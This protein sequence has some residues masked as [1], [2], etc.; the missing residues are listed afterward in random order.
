[1]AENH[2]YEWEY[3]ELKAEL[4]TRFVIEEHFG[5]FASVKD[6]KDLM[7]PEEVNLL[8]RLKEY[9]NSAMISCLMAPLYPSKSRNVLWKLRKRVN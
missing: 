7:T 1:M 9:Y 2:I 5:T 4:E 6:Y 3:E 8:N